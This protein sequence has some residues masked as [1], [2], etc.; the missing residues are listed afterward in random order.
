M[1]H[2]ALGGVTERLH[3]PGQPAGVNLYSS[4]F[5]AHLIHEILLHGSIRPRSL[6]V[7]AIPVPVVSPSD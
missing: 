1:R 2:E 6:P 7:I 4:G 3:T 5:S